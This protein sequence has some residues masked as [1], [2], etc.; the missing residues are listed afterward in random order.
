MLIKKTFC[1]LVFRAMLLI[2]ILLPCSV[3]A[4]ENDMTAT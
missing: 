3:F 1:R 4:E 2:I